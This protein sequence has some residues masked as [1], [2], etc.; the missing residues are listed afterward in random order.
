MHS[1]LYALVMIGVA[2]AAFSVHFWC[3]SSTSVSN[4]WMLS[5]PRCWQSCTRLL[6]DLNDGLDPCDFAIVSHFTGSGDKPFCQ[7]ELFVNALYR[8]DSTGE[9]MVLDA[10]HLDEG[11]ADFSCTRTGLFRVTKQA[12]NEARIGLSRPLIISLSF[13]PSMRRRSVFPHASLPVL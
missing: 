11:E 7:D 8:L 9:T 3:F 13:A 2:M 5:D 12:P 1:K 10:L 4:Q 6:P